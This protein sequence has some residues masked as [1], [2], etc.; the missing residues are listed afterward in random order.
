MFRANYIARERVRLHRES[1]VTA[2]FTAWQMLAAQIKKPPAF[3]KYLADLGL[4]AQE[5]KAT[6]EDL[7]REA[8]ASFAK[9]EQILARARGMSSG[10]R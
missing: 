2:A 8:E 6:K 7:E 9:V 1:M 3:G 10:S 4:E 5:R